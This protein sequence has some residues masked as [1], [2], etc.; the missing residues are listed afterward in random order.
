MDLFIVNDNPTKNGLAF[1][2]LLMKFSGLTSA[3]LFMDCSMLRLPIPK[4]K[5]ENEKGGSEE[6][7]R[8]GQWV[9]ADALTD[10]WWLAS[11]TCDLHLH[12]LGHNLLV[13]GSS[14]CEDSTKKQK[15]HLTTPASNERRK[16]QSMR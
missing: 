13:L 7:E 9:S 10:G 15:Y 12:A 6:M 4:V 5:V 8:G 2:I 14:C 16:G 3:V 11:L 1:S